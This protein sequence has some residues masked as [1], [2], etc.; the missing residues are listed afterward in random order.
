MSMDVDQLR[1]ELALYGQEHLLQ[2]WD[3][4]SPEHQAEL[5]HDI[6]E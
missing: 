3:T 1:S 2:F 4:L 6:R 5:V